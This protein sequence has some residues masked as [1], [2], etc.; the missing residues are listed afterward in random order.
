[1]SVVRPKA[2]F[3]AFPRIDAKRFNIHDDEQFALDFLRSKQVLVVNGRG[4][5]WPTP[6]HFRIVYLPDVDLLT[7]AMGKLKEFLADY[8]QK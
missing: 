5:N 4:F 6:D 8:R 2:A 1:M 3:Y 7:E